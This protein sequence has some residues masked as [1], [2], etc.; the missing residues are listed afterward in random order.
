MNAREPNLHVLTLDHTSINEIAA[1]LGRGM[2]DNPIHARV[3]KED[4]QHRARCHTR[5]LQTLLAASPS[6]AIEGVQ[7]GQALIGV[8]AS[9]P[10]AHCQ[11]VLS[12]RMRLLGTA[13]VFGP[14]TAAR[15]L[16][17]NRTWARHDLREPH[18]HL[19]PV[20]VA[21]HLRGRGIGGLL[22][23]RHTARLDSVGAVGYLET[24]RP[25][26]VGFYRRF[27]YTVVDEVA[28]LGVPTWLMR[29]PSA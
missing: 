28:V 16:V 11:P 6:L 19:G 25:E 9:A 18:V 17:W 7:Q 13:A 20:S 21:R 29:R 26:A 12:A 1:L 24:D 5:L 15:L 8:A 27:G 14:S 10:P 3:Y 23:M 2:A 4:D 22:L